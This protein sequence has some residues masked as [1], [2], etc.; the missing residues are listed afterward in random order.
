[1]LK[2]LSKLLHLS[3]SLV[4]TLVVVTVILLAIIIA[5]GK[6][7]TPNISDYK[8]NIESLISNATKQDVT[9]GSIEASW[10]RLAPK[11]TIKNMQIGDEF[12]IDSL[13]IEPSIVDS[14]WQQ[15]LIMQ[16]LSVSGLALTLRQRENGFSVSGYEIKESQNKGEPITLKKLDLFL[17]QQHRVQINNLRLRIELQDA[18]VLD[19][20]VEQ[21]DLSTLKKESWLLAK[22]QVNAI[23][24][25][26]QLE[27]QLD[28]NGQGFFDAY[29]KH[30]R[31]DWSPWLKAVFPESLALESMQVSGEH[32]LRLYGETLQSSTSLIQIQDIALKYTQTG[33]VAKLQNLSAQFNLDKKGVGNSDYT[34][35]IKDL[36]F[37]QNKTK[38]N[39][40]LHEFSYIDNEFEILSDSIDL[41]MLSSLIAPFDKTQ[42][43]TKMQPKGKLTNSIFTVSNN[44]NISYELTSNIE[45]VY[46]SPANGIPG[47]GNLSG[48]IVMNEQKGH[49]SFENNNIQVWDGGNFEYPLYLDHLKAD[50]YWQI[51]KSQE[52]AYLYSPNLSGVD[53]KYGKANGQVFVTLF[54]EKKLD[55]GYESN[56]ALIL[57]MN[58][59]KFYALEELYPTKEQ[60]IEI[61]SWIVNNIYEA[62]IDKVSFIFNGPVIS[63]S[64]KAK[65]NSSFVLSTDLQNTSIKFDP[66][67]QS[68]YGLSGNVTL[69]NKLVYADIKKGEYY[70]SE[71][72]NAKAEISGK[73][74]SHLYLTGLGKTNA[75]NVKQFLTTSPL[76]T[77]ANI[78]N[79]ADLWEMSGDIDLDLQLRVPFSS[80]PVQ[81]WVKSNLKDVVLIMPEEELGFESI[82]G[83]IF[84]DDLLG[85]YGNVDS[86]FFG[87]KVKSTIKTEVIKD[88][89]LTESSIWDYHIYT[90]GHLDVQDVS[91]WFG[92]P[93]L[94]K[95]NGRIAYDSI[96][97]IDQDSLK[98]HLET[99]LVG[100]DFVDVPEP[101]GTLSEGPITQP[102]PTIVDVIIPDDVDDLEVVFSYNNWL[103]GKLLMEGDYL[104]QGVITNTG[105]LDYKDDIGIY[106]D[107]KLDYVDADFWTAYIMEAQALNE[108]NPYNI[109]WPVLPEGTPTVDER[110]KSVVVTSD[111]ALGGNILFY[112]MYA[113]MVQNDI[114]WVIDYKSVESEG[115]IG[116]P[117]S[118][119]EPVIIAIDYLAL[120]DKN[121]PQSDEE[122][123]PDAP[124]I[125]LLAQSMSPKDIPITA[126]DVRQVS[127][128]GINYG[129]W[130]LLME[131]HEKG[132][133]IKNVRGIINGVEANG[134]LNWFVDDNN[135]HVSSIKMA[136]MTPNTTQTLKAFRA[137][138]A[139]KA[140]KTEVE[141]VMNWKG[142]PS[143]F[144]GSVANGTLKI[145]ID[146][147]VITQLPDDVGPAIGLFK[148]IGL[149]NA[150]K[151]FSRISLDFTDIM[152][153]GQ[154]FDSIRAEVV[155]NDGVATISSKRKFTMD[156]S[157]M[158]FSGYGDYNMLND[159]LNMRGQI[160]V[161][162]S[163]TIATV[164]LLTGIAAPPAAA[165]IFFSEKIFKKGLEKLTTWHFDIVGN[166]NDL[167]SLYPDIKHGSLKE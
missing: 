156:S 155:L 33:K 159:N 49:L 70:N 40:S 89:T 91:R 69:Q 11:I 114:G 133:I 12:S 31:W 7:F 20:L 47:F 163:S 60:D 110:I 104:T 134:N 41:G 82:N 113:T 30:D 15:K 136:L 75:K 86:M 23:N 79:T 43:I 109:D 101:I 149:L 119:F 32:W 78:G 142:S 54:S 52:V 107:V 48:N 28:S 138:P 143:A 106:I 72:F 154:T 84:Y 98:L 111:T 152:K 123:D 68:V 77:E 53:E 160:I 100:A 128:E 76:R 22:A 164:G 130:Q 146:D 126:I 65:K 145:A 80:A 165:I 122:I 141:L 27:L 161:P 147:G 102:R 148:F 105:P 166:I 3:V 144:K 95:F 62:Q 118:D 112:D 99:D 35:T 46:T 19:V 55:Q 24:Q 90:S 26:T 151:I 17:K 38:W 137:P 6:Q 139:L 162:F 129:S 158:R 115:Q 132:V 61:R 18:T 16:Q 140:A 116:V 124:V 21:A 56:L 2:F 1:M 5:L 71:I 94:Q 51:D 57:G 81:A 45:Q 131:P 63:R 117:F 8:T 153:S 93:V 10:V 108:T 92:E 88:A 34:G 127:Y 9:I 120:S 4:W 29:I 66:T 44:K 42:T 96:V 13:K 67:W 73:E 97:T 121:F 14:I 103:D 50:V 25:Q 36:S 150:S 83:E 85:I 39:S 167:D 58:S 135:N 157:S 87:E 125:D 74:T 64:K 37:S 59:P